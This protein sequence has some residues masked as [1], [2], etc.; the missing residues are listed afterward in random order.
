MIEYPSVKACGPNLRELLLVS[1]RRV[2]ALRNE[3]V[4]TSNAAFSQKPICNWEQKMSVIVAG[5]IRN[6][7]QDPLA[8][9][10]HLQRVVNYAGEIHGL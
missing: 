7:R 6:D 5:F 4:K 8:T 3:R 9:L 1:H 2:R 10:D